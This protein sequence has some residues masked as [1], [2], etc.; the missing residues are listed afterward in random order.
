MNMNVICAVDI[1]D[2]CV[3][4]IL[5]P[6]EAVVVVVLVVVPVCVHACT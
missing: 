3:Y 6:V 4:A 1:L 2:E 5:V